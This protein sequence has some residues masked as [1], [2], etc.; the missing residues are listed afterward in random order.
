[1]K[2]FL[3]VWFRIIFFLPFHFPLE[4]FHLMMSSDGVTMDHT[5]SPTAERRQD[6]PQQIIDCEDKDTITS[7]DLGGDHVTSDSHYVTCINQGKSVK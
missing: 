7:H 2:T 1:M 4:E 5:R 6:D 3:S